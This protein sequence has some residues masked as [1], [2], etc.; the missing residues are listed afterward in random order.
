LLWFQAVGV[1]LFSCSAPRREL[2]GPLPTHE[3]HEVREVRSTW[4][5]RDTGAI[6]RIR[7]VD[8]DGGVNDVPA[9]GGV[10]DINSR[11]H[12]SIDKDRLR[13]RLRREYGLE[14]FTQGD[15]ELLFALQEGAEQGLQSLSRLS[16][17]MKSFTAAVSVGPPSDE[18]VAA[19]QAGLA[20][21]AS[22]GADLLSRA[23]DGDLAGTS[24][25][26]RIERRLLDAGVVSVE[27]QYFICFDECARE[28]DSLRRA[29]DA[30]LEE[31]AVFVQLGAWA[32]AGSRPRPLN[33]PGFDTYPEGEFFRVERWRVAP[34]PDQV[35]LIEELRA[36]ASDLNR[37]DAR[38]GELVRNLAH[39]TARGLFA[40]V[41]EC[42]AE[43]RSDLIGL[44]AEGDRILEVIRRRIGELQLEL[45]RYATLVSTRIAKYLDGDFLE[46]RSIGELLQALR[47]DYEEIRRATESLVTNLRGLLDPDAILDPGNGDPD[48]LERVQDLVEGLEACLGELEEEVRALAGQLASLF[49]IQLSASRINTAALEFGDRVL[50][51]DIRSLPETSVLDLKFTGVRAENDSVLF[52]LGTGR[53]DPE[54]GQPLEAVRQLQAVYVDL[55][56]V[57]VHF[58]TSVNLIFADPNGSAAISSRFQFAPAY[59]I[60]LKVGRRDS[61]LYNRL[62]DA[63]VGLNLALLDFDGDDNPELGVGGVVSILRDILQAGYGYNLNDDRWYGFFGLGLPLGAIQSALD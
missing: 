38:L 4:P 20:Q 24:L 54:T 35:R 51:H 32:L 26:G 22:V 5:S 36:V 43:I 49:G 6:F 2:S 63:G 34:S 37:D 23:L 57:L 58:D 7:E 11:L 13:A 19:L 12:V 53:V 59:S 8:E 28:A 18:D 33:L 42:V 55:F 15:L 31:Q 10:V 14:S 47:S 29:L 61:P 50:R 44:D 3:G 17:A 45:E 1:A 46:G 52:K 40:L 56:R 21:A 62:I 16:P 25:A 60:L 41:N 30:Q 9:G 48:A 39:S 27:E